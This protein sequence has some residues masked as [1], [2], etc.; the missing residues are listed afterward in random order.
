[1]IY[2]GIFW[3]FAHMDASDG[4]VDGWVDGAQKKEQYT[5]CWQLLPKHIHP[6]QLQWLLRTSQKEVDSCWVRVCVCVCVCVF[7]SSLIGPKRIKRRRRKMCLFSFSFS[8]LETSQHHP[9]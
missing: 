7:L 2:G 8:D 1:V 5:K 3:Y 9:V 4:W 6:L